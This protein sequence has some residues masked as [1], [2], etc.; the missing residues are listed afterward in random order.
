MG[1]SKPEGYSA[2][3]EGQVASSHRG[4]LGRLPGG[5]EDGP[6]CRK[7][8][9]RN[10][11]GGLLSL[12]GRVRGGTELGNQLRAVLSPGPPCSE[13]SFTAGRTRNLTSDHFHPTPSPSHLVFTIGNISIV[14][15]GSILVSS[16]LWLSQGHFVGNVVKL[17]WMPFCTRSLGHGWP[18]AAAAA[19]AQQT[20]PRLLPCWVRDQNA[21]HY[22]YYSIVLLFWKP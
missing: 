21:N 15:V 6:R 9:G 19:L 22:L 4:S 20:L 18:W 14:F 2:W 7:R 12:C 1:R 13:H 3:S 16:I 10:E 11:W 17:S 8:R 5:G